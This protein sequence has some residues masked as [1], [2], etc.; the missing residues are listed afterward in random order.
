MRPDRN[1]QRRA[2]LHRDF[3]RRLVEASDRLE[4]VGFIPTAMVTDGVKHVLT[5]PSYG[6][7]AHLVQISS[8]VGSGGNGMVPLYSAVDLFGK[9]YPFRWSF[10]VVDDDKFE[11]FKA[12]SLAPLFVSEFLRHNP[13]AVR[14]LRAAFTKF[15]HQRGMYWDGEAARKG[16]KTSSDERRTA[17]PGDFP[18]RGPGLELRDGTQPWTDGRTGDAVL[19]PKG[20]RAVRMQLP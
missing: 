1:G 19:R 6:R 16:G 11:E 13:D 17:K 18:R 20:D 8:A 15:L 7:P 2:Y 12:G 10:L 14:G 4:R 5:D 9:Q 3:R